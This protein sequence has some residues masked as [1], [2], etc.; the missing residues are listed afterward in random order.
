MSLVS[1]FQL[2]IYVFFDYGLESKKP[3]I[4][5][6][7]SQDFTKPFVIKI[8]H[9]I[10]HSPIIHGRATRVKEW[11]SGTIHIGVTS[12]PYLHIAVINRKQYGLM[13]L[14]PFIYM[15]MFS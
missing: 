1:I 8:S 10:K 13:M 7:N 11:G 14:W 6:T 5:D 4:F 15:E 9:K 3:L 12:A 2:R